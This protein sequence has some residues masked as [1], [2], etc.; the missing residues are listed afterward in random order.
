[1]KQAVVSSVRRSVCYP[2]YRNWALSM[3]TLK[4]VEAIFR[5]GKSTVLKCLLDI[6]QIFA[7]DSDCRYVFNDLYITDYCVWIQGV[8]DSVFATYANAIHK[9]SQSITKA[10]VA[11]NLDELELAASLGALEVDENESEATGTVEHAGQ[12]DS[13]D[14]EGSEKSVDRTQYLLDKLTVNSNGE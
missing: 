4:D 12:L 1:V 3:Q 9:V 6:H 2:L 14:D 5:Q 11:L 7:N 8:E 10:D 13:D